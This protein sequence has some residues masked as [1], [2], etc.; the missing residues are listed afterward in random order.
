MHVVYPSRRTLP[1]R[2]RAFVDFAADYYK[3]AL[4]QSE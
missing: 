1:L 4:Q 2:V 3:K